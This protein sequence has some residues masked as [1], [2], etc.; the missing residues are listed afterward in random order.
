MTERTVFSRQT[1]TKAASTPLAN[2]SK[3]CS[4]SARTLPPAIADSLPAAFETAKRSSRRSACVTRASGG[5]RGP[6]L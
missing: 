2:G 4:K 5:R 6:L 3:R 1:A